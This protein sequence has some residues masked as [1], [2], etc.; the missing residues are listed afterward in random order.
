M[1]QFS[2]P[3]ELRTLITQRYG[4]TLG[5]AD[6]ME[7]G[8]EC[9]IWQV[10]ANEGDVVV[11][12]SPPWRSGERLTRTH[13]VTLALQSTLSQVVAPILA[14]DGGTLFRYQQQ[15][16]ALFPYITGAQL[17]QDNSAQR[18]EAA[19]L[20][21]SLHNALLNCTP[22]STGL[23]RERLLG[24]P[25]LSPTPDPAELVDLEL[26]TWHASLSGR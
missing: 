8:D 12:V 21:A 23:E 26:D 7:G 16:V 1:Q 3:G 6:Q 20:L 24:A 18:Q 15:S 9:L 4:I 22:M 14:L 13:Q 25:P 10:T 17:D 5:E 11:R 19:C 2:L